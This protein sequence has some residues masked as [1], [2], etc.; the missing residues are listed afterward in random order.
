MGFWTTAQVTRT[1]RMPYSRVACGVHVHPMGARAMRACASCEDLSHHVQKVWHSLETFLAVI[2]GMRIGKHPMDQHSSSMTYPFPRHGKTPTY[3]TRPRTTHWAVISREWCRSFAGRSRA[4][5]KNHVLLIRSAQRKQQ[6][7]P[8]KNKLITRKKIL[9]LDTLPRV[10]SWE[11][12][13]CR[14]NSGQTWRVF[15]L[16]STCLVVILERCTVNQTIKNKQNTSLADMLP[17]RSQ[18]QANFTRRVRHRRRAVVSRVFRRSSSQRLSYKTMSFFTK[19]N[20]RGAG[21]YGVALEQ[22]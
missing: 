3:A 1:E 19:R 15:T 12:S 8:L 22:Y 14:L 4:T 5:D 13:A 7:V 17:P 16:S 6:T 21:T 2:P 9:R 18:E 20:R 10:I 11:S